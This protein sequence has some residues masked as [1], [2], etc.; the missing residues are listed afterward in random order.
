M[1]N[2]TIREIEL[3]DLSN[4][5]LESLDSLKQASNLTS[6]QAKQIFETIKQNPSQI[7][8]VVLKDSKVIGAATLLIEQK[9][10]HH[11]KCVGHIE[12]VVISKEFQKSKIGTELIKTLLQR[13]ESE[14]C[15]KTVLNCLENISPF[16][17]KIGFIP[18]L[19]GM[20]YDHR[21]STN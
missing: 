18:H 15:Y 21:K 6:D 17:E 13:A 2:L 4:G 7:I 19:K 8:Y 10:I 1:S 3:S 5:F 11:G 20:R 9:F 16:Y 12:D 14:G